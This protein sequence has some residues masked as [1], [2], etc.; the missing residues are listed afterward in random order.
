MLSGTV[1]YPGFSPPGLASLTARLFAR[2]I[3]SLAGLP[4]GLSTGS[5]CSAAACLKARPFGHSA[6]PQ[7]VGIFGLPLTSVVQTTNTFPRYSQ[8]H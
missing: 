6:T 7:V 2:C 5:I 3:G 4:G 1:G 8:S